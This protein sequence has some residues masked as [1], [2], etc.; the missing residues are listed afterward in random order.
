MTVFT[1]YSFYSLNSL[2]SSMNNKR[3][4]MLVSLF[5]YLKDWKRNLN[6][7]CYEIASFTFIST[8]ILA[9]NYHWW[10][11][12]STFSGLERNAPA[13]IFPDGHHLCKLNYEGFTM[14]NYEVSASIPLSTMLGMI[15]CWDYY[16]PDILLA[17]IPC[18]N[19]LR[20]VW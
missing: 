1:F 17:H 5:I 7:L 14:I 20:G 6:D 8:I 2:S 18:E 11:A 3:D 9:T 10:G 12:R 15:N 13:R 19:Y 16:I 4:H